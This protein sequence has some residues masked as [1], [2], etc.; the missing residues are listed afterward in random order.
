MDPISF[1]VATAVASGTIIPLFG[2]MICVCQLRRR[3]S[4]LE[5]RTMLVPGHTAIPIPGDYATM[6]G[7]GYGQQIYFRPAPSAPPA[8]APPPPPP[9]PHLV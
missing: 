7:N 2:L 4:D 5:E 3:V 1:F 8:W 6:G 9:A